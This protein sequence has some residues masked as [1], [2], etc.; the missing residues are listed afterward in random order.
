LLALSCQKVENQ[1]PLKRFHFPFD[2]RRILAACFLVASCSAFAAA[3]KSGSNS[4]AA[5]KVAGKPWIGAGGVQ[6]TTADIMADPAAAKVPSAITQK[7]KTFRDRKHLPQDSRALSIASWPH[8]NSTQTTQSVEPVFSSPQTVGTTFDAATGNSTNGPFPP[9]TMG[10][11]GPTQF[12]LFI[13]GLLKT[14]SKTTGLADGVINANP[15][16]F[17]SSVMTPAVP[18]NST[19][20]PQIR[21]DRLTNRWIL[22]IVDTPGTSPATLGN[23]PN[24]ILIAVSDAASN[25]VISGSTV[26]TFF[27]VQQNTVGGGDTG[28]Y[29]DNP[30]L[31]VDNNA[32]YVGGD[33]LNASTNVFVTTSGFVIRKSS[34]LSGGPVVVT[35][36][37]GLISSGEGP[38]SPRGVDNYDPAA[39]EGYF[40]GA[41][42]AAFGRMVFRRVGTPGGTPTIS[43]NI[44]VSVPTTS[45]PISVPHLG[46]T[47]GTNGQLDGLDDRLLAAHIRNGKLWTAHSIAVDAT[48]VA[49]AGGA[50]RRNAVRWYEFIVPAGSG[51]PTVNQSGTIFDSAASNPKFH[52]VPSVMVSGQGHA[53][54]GFSVAGNND[55]INAGTNGRLAGDTLG[56]QGTVAL[57]TS[58]ASAYNPSGDTGGPLGRRWGDYSFTSLDP[59]DDMTMWTVQEFCDGTNTWGT[60]VAKLLAPPP[61]TPVSS[62]PPS[63]QSGQSSVSVTITGTSSSG[64]AFF[65]PGAGFANRI[66]ASVS[67]GVTVNSV[68]FVD[69]THVTLSLNTIGATGGAKDLT[70][71][72]PDG[73]SAIGLGILNITAGPLQLLSAV[74]RKTHGVAGTFDVNL[75]VS[76]PPFGVECRSSSGNHTFVFSFSNS[77]N[78][79][80]ASVTGGTG[81]AGAPTF[82]AN[83]VTVN[84]TGVTDIQVLTVTL[85]GVMDSFAQSLPNASVSANMLIGDTTASKTVNASDITQV[86]IQSGAL[87]SGANFRT[88]LNANGSVNAAD[89]SLVKTRSGNALP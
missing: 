9:D 51:T 58:S 35:A 65:D 28:E 63:V 7:R 87:V 76:G 37:R 2:W 18:A 85:S 53:A 41:S 61:A 79:A 27:F 4:T 78:S 39:N 67:G 29:L 21:Y 6:R 13:N 83:K 88:D 17:F 56:T 22:T 64:S 34:V 59:Q 89:I 40:V 82:S 23:L 84:V 60:Q 44:L 14:F 74:S 38:E 80:T 11:V 31:G 72:N 50:G 1:S 43:S 25:G 52:W 70:I 46:N 32:L 24:R 15:D 77:I 30:S 12:V 68:T 86:K 26:W 47:G 45:F 10:A 75:P 69:A 71:T 33:M 19:S 3:D 57:Y 48:G 20:N 81:V 62:N 16:A 55:R 8:L 73:Q 36:F 49:A 54:F 42:I 5:D 66:A